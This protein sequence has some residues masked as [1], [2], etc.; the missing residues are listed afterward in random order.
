[1]GIGGRFVE[2]GC[3]GGETRGVVHKV[4]IL[5]GCGVVGFLLRSVGAN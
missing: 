5:G 4:G 1:M 3:L 2:F